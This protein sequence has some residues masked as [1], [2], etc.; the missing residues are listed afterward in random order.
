MSRS[1]T[2]TREQRPVDLLGRVGDGPLGEPGVH[3]RER[4]EELGRQADR[5]LCRR[6]LAHLVDVAPRFRRGASE[7]LR[8]A[9]A[10]G[11]AR[12]D[13]VVEHRVE[14]AV[15]VGRAE[16]LR[17][18][19]DP[20]LVDRRRGHLDRGSQPDLGTDHDAL[21]AV[22]RQSCDLVRAA[23]GEVDPGRVR[24]GRRRA[25]DRAVDQV[26]AGTRERSREVSSRRRRDGVQV[27]DERSIAPC[28]RDDRVDC[29]GR[30]GGWDDREDDVGLDQHRR[31]VADV[32]EPGIGRERA[33]PLAATLE[34]DD[35]ACTTSSQSRPDRAPHLPCAD[36]PDDQRAREDSNLRPAD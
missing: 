26:E 27:G 35:D 32:L 12:L 24:P 10:V 29:T 34:G 36:Q 1:R 8:G 15:R 33:R 17:E 13:E 5:R 14:D 4:L 16:R 11:E 20:S 23:A 2:S 6:D 25:G 7:R 21:H 18:H 30:L 19:R 22:E 3:D 28:A 31:E 9:L